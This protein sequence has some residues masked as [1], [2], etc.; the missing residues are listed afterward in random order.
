MNKTIN[1]VKNG[2]SYSLPYELKRGNRKSVGIEIKAGGTICIRIPMYFPAYQLSSIIETKKDWILDAYLKQKNK[3]PIVL[4][5]DPRLAV[6]EKQYKKAAADYF[7]QRVEHYIKQTG[8][9]YS[10]IT[11]RDQKTRWGSRSS[12]G[13]LS[14]NW[15]LMLAPPRV[16]DYVVVHELCHIHHMNHSKEFWAQVEQIM[17]DYKVYRKWL[18]ENGSTL[19]LS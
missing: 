4:S 13:T 8:G 15:R 16:L 11:I 9:G 7:Y 19:T 14:F 5:K 2:V 6:L 3:T 1:L 17:P 10:R 18:K 12:N